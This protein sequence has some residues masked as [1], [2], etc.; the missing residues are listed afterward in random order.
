MDWIQLAEVESSDR[1]SEVGSQLSYFEMAGEFTGIWRRKAFC[2]VNT[3][4]W[5]LL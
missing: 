5:G 3:V 4:P 1:H 2:C